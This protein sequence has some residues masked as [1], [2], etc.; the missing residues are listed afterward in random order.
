MTLFNFL[1][2]IAL[3][4][5]L[6]FFPIFLF[7]SVRDLY[8]RNREKDKNVFQYKI[9]NFYWNGIKVF[10]Y[11]FFFGIFLN[12]SRFFVSYE[13][14][15]HEISL[16][17][18]PSMISFI[19]FIVELYYSNLFLF[20]YVLIII[21]LSLSCGILFWRTV[22]KYFLHELFSLFIYVYSTSTTPWMGAEDLVELREKR[23][24]IYF[25]QSMWYYERCASLH[26]HYDLIRYFIVTFLC[27]I[28]DIYRYYYDIPPREDKTLFIRIG[29]KLITWCHRRVS[30]YIFFLSPLLVFSYD[31][32]CND[33]VI[34]HVFYWI[35][36]YIPMV[37]YYRLVNFL[38]RHLYGMVD[39]LYDIYYGN[40][41]YT[42][43]VPQKL[44]PFFDY[45][46]INKCEYIIGLDGLQNS[47]FSLLVYNFRFT[48]D[49][50]QDIYINDDDIELKKINEDKYIQIENGE[51][52]DYIGGDTSPEE[53]NKDKNLG[54]EKTVV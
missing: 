8:M 31:C 33:F 34:N 3:L 12:I 28:M 39:L 24:N 38:A 2:I 29:N 16:D 23:N 49:S 52:W 14:W 21:F 44:R 51:E 1:L 30:K 48:Y 18:K 27:H 40:D 22:H 43:C 9:D 25:K 41:K 42:F 4:S 5:F 6:I 7:I 13:I 47:D 11:I 19:S 50:V 35:T 15:K 32:I 54:S 46:I 53:V 45:A 26:G 17:L 10:L 20:F 36:I 37:Q